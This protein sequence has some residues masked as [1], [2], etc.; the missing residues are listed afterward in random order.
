MP[1]LRPHT[2]LARSIILT[3]WGQT[4]DL[5]RAGVSREKALEAITPGIAGLLESQQDALLESQRE[6]A[7][8][9]EAA[10]GRK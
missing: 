6:T 7:L 2:E 5:R 9:L 4:A 1:K 3:V 10:L 8:A